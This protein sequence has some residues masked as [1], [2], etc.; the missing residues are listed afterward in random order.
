MGGATADLAEFAYWPVI[1]DSRDEVSYAYGFY[2]SPIIP[3]MTKIKSAVEI[4][5][6][7]VER[8]VEGHD[9]FM[10]Q[11]HQAAWRDL[12]HLASARVYSH[13]STRIAIELDWSVVA[14]RLLEVSAKT[15]TRPPKRLRLNA[16]VSI[17]GEA[18]D[19]E[20]TWRYSTFFVS[21]HLCN[22]FLAMNISAPGS[23]DFSG[24]QVSTD[25]APID[26]ALNLSAYDYDY[27]WTSSK[28][29]MWPAIQQVPL[30]ICF[31]WLAPL[32]KR[33]VSIA[34]SNTERLM[35]SMLRVAQ[36]D[37]SPDSAIW[38]CSGL[39]ALFPTSFG[40]TQSQLNS[41]IGDLL[42]VTSEQ[43]GLLKSYLSA[44]Y[45]LRNA[46][47]HGKLPIAHPFSNESI[48]ERVEDEF[49][50]YV[51]AHLHGVRLLLACVQQ[52]A[53]KVP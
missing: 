15:R 43:Q 18:V 3:V 46:F 33:V 34:N 13:G 24:V 40:K 25:S 21:Y 27:A 10:H 26:T 23:A 51:N 30:D 20:F 36:M 47:A 12:A 48:D 52:L 19:P 14:R 39:E 35:L 49:D 29:G 4:L 17:S 6:P 45:S 42:S 1:E 53:L 32:E 9:E 7:S 41:S 2:R 16:K 31:E 44:V 8:D 5:F 22:V 38:I 28:E 50:Q 11:A 37:S